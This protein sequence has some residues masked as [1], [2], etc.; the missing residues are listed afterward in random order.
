[1]GKVRLTYYTSRTDS[2]AALIMVQKTSF[3]FLSILV[4]AAVVN[5]KAHGVQRR[6]TAGNIRN[7]NFLLSFM[8]V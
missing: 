2:P 1:M 7:W 3:I 6:Q 5:S 8:V 4:V